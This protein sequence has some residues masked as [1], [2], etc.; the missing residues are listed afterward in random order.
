MPTT[1]RTI[2]IFLAALLF[3]G[4]HHKDT[5]TQNGLTAATKTVMAN[6]GWLMANGSR[7]VGRWVVLRS[8]TREAGRMRKAAHHRAPPLC[9]GLTVFVHTGRGT[10]RRVRLPYQPLWTV[11]SASF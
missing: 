8:R 7:R 1:V 9:V 3:N 10:S 6:G 4:L 11:P 5:K 2:V